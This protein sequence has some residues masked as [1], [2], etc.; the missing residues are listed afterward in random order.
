MTTSYDVLLS[1]FIIRKNQRS[2]FYKR[3]TNLARIFSFTFWYQTNIMTKYHK[4]NINAVF[5]LLTDIHAFAEKVTKCAKISSKLSI[6]LT[7]QI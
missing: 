3:N 4:R 5:L 2:S 6:K 1:N 7:V